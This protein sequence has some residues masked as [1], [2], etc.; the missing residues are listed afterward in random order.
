MVLG[1]YAF[2]IFCLVLSLALP[3]LGIAL[4]FVASL[5]CAVLIQATSRIYLRRT[6]QGAPSR[7][8]TAR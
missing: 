5:A 7:Q 2:G 1:Y 6:Q 8:S 3:P 4:A